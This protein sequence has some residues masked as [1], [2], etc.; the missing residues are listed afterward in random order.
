MCFDA[1]PAKQEDGAE[2]GGLLLPRPAPSSPAGQSCSPHRV[3]SP[4]AHPTEQGFLGVP[5]LGVG[6]A[7]PRSSQHPLSGEG[8]TQGLRAKERAKK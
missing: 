6:A 5:A 1:P 2:H 8:H 7:A 3:L 4:S